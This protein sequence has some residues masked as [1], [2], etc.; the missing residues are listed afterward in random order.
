MKTNLALSIFSSALG[1]MALVTRGGAIVRISF[2][3]RGGKAAR[4][5]VATDLPQVRDLAAGRRVPGPSLAILRRRPAGRFSRPADRVA[6]G[7]AVSAAGHAMLPASRLR[8]DDHLRA[9]CGQG[10]LAGG[11][12]GRRQLH[13]GQSAAVGGAVSSGGAG[14]RSPGALLRSRRNAHE[15]AAAG[16]GTGGKSAPSGGATLSGGSRL[17][18]PDG[19]TMSRRR[20]SPDMHGA[21]SWP[22]PAASGEEKTSCRRI[23][24]KRRGD[25]IR[26]LMP[27]ARG[28][29]ADRGWPR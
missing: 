5:A 4:Q 29:V 17:W 22:Q 21:T 14:R 12:P 19:R 18:L 15:A 16:N 28:T 11:R 3:H 9:A 10:R 7:H 1:W 20:K 27:P 24:D 13:G 26:R 6:R 2:G 8:P 23:G 25:V